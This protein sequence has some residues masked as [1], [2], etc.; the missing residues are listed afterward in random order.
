MANI[1][2]FVMLVLAIFKDLPKFP[3]LALQHGVST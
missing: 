3:F 2:P 1:V